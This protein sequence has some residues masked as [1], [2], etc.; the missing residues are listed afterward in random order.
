MTRLT[1]KEDLIEFANYDS[2]IQFIDVGSD[3]VDIY[4]EHEVDNVVTLEAAIN[5]TRSEM[6]AIV[7]LLFAKYV[8]GKSVAD[9][10]AVSA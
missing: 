5:L 10:G 7:A 9:V 1:T 6:S 8:Q 4:I 3:H 2:M